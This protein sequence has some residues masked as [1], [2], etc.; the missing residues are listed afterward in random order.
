MNVMLICENKSYVTIFESFSPETK[1]L[2][3]CFS[4]VRWFLYKFNPP[5]TPPAPFT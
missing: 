3:Y 5:P 4:L 1:S 2:F